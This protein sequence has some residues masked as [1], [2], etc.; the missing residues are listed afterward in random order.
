MRTENEEAIAAETAAAEKSSQSL[1]QP[2]KNPF[3]SIPS[4]PYPKLKQIWKMRPT[5]TKERLGKLRNKITC[6]KILT[7]IPNQT[8]VP[9][10]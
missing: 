9:L 7:Q 4:Q 1:I 6:L 5:R 10:P 2:P 3:P 8:P